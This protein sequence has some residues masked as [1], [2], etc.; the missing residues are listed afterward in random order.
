MGR[1]A[2]PQETCLVRA[3]RRGHRHADAGA[4][5]RR[6]RSF[7]AVDAGD[8]WRRLRHAAPP[9]GDQPAALES[10]RPFFVVAPSIGSKPSTGVTGGLSGNIA[11]IDG[12]PK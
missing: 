2:P 4:V 6:K 11:F 10:H 9:E 8:L 7:T 3:R 12:E 5:A 1:S